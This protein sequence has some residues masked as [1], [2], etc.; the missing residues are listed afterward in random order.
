MSAKN[1]H[2]IEVIKYINFVVTDKP[3]L[4]ILIGEKKMEVV[5]LIFSRDTKPQHPN[6]QTLSRG[7]P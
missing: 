4:S 1:T 2:T 7:H 5:S 6:K 3:R